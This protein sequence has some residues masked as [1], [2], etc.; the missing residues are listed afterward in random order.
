MHKLA[1]AQRVK[2]FPAP[3]EPR[4][5]FPYSKGPGICLRPERHGSN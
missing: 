2:K 5:S 3:L 4:T 1:V